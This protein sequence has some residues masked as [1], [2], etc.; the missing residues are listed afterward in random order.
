ME[1]EKLSNIICSFP[2]VYGERL[3]IIATR[4]ER[5]LAAQEELLEL[6]RALANTLH[7]AEMERR[8]RTVLEAYTKE[9]DRSHEKLER[10]LTIRWLSMTSL[11][12][13]IVYLIQFFVK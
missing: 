12:G 6:N 9:I 13:F 8:E 10:R 7:P 1:N 2:P 5:I 4:L 11:F 3:G